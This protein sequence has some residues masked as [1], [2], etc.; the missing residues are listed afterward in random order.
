[1]AR[2]FAV[3]AVLL[4]VLLPTTSLRCAAQESQATFF[5]R[6]A[7]NSCGAYLAAD[8]GTKP[9]YLAWADGYLTARAE[10]GGLRRFATRD[11]NDAR[12]MAWIAA[13]CQLRPQQSFYAGVA[14]LDDALRTGTFR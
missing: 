4:P 7:F 14:A 9:A 5:D 6:E 8:A 13:F 3:S 12:F 2:I 1:M 10:D 11:G